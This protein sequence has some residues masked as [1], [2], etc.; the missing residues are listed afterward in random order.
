MKLSFRLIL[1]IFFALNE[2]LSAQPYYFKR[3]EVE[4][5]LSTNTIFASLQ[6]KHG[7]LW[8]GTVDGLNRF[9]GYTFKVFRPDKEDPGSI[10]TDMVSGLIEDNKGTLWVGTGKGLYR[11]N[12]I[13]EDFTLVKPTI[14]M[15]ITNLNT[16][17]YGNVW[18]MSDAKIFCYSPAR[19]ELHLY[20]A[21]NIMDASSLCV[22]PD[23]SIWVGTSGGLVRELN[24]KNKS[25]KSYDVFKHSKPAKA[26]YILRIYDA[27]KYLMLGT[28][29][30]GVK[31]FN[32]ESKTYEDILTHNKDKSE[33]YVRDFLHITGDEYWI[34]TEVGIFIYNLSTRKVVNLVK[35]NVNPYSLSDNAVYTLCKDREGGIW[36][37]SFFGGVNYYP[38]QYNLFEKFFPTNSDSSISGNAVRE[39]CK[40]DYGNIWVGTEDAALNKFN[41]K[42]SVFTHFSPTGSKTDISYTNIH[43]LLAKGN[44]LW[45]GTFEHGL[46]IM[47]IRTN[48][49]IRHYDSGDAPDEL[50]SN[51]IVTFL[52]TR[53]GKT[54]IGTTRGLYLYNEEKNNFT[55]VNLFNNDY[56]TF[57]YSILEDHSGNIWIGTIRDGLIRLDNNTGKKSY[58]KNDPRKSKSLNSNRINKILESSGGTIWLATDGGGLC[59]YV[60]GSN[61]FKSYTIN[62]GLPSNF[63]FGILE[64]SR[65]NLWISTSKGLVCFNP[66]SEKITTFTKS[67]GLLNDKFNYNSAFKDTTDGYMYFG[68]VKGMIRFNPDKFTENTYI[69]PVYI[70]GFEV[71]NKELPVDKEN[72]P[73]KKSIILT[74][75][76]VLTYDQSSFNIKFAALSFTAPEMAEYAYK[77]EGLDSRW[78]Y[79]KTNRQAYFT[80]LGPGTYT[81]HVKASNSSGQWNK[82]DTKLVVVILP[83]IW[84]SPAAYLIYM[85]ILLAAFYYIIKRYDRK[86]KEKNRRKIELLAHK[87]EQEVYQAKINF[88]T[89]VAH[90][91]RTPLTLIKGPMER[92]INKADEVP[93]IK[94]NLLIMERNTGRLLELTEQLLD[95]RQ[96]ETN[97][98]SLNFSNVDIVSLLHD[99]HQR[100]ESAAEQKKITFQLDVPAEPVNVSTDV[101]AFNK[102]ISN[103]ISNAIKYSEK[104][105]IVSLSQIDEEKNEFTIQVKNDGYHIPADMKDKIFDS[106]FRIKETRKQTGTGIGL[107]LSR[108]LAELLQGSLTLDTNDSTL[109]VFILNLPT[110]LKR[111]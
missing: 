109:N 50:K 46:D 49:V 30:Q 64:D 27:G 34:A 79:L 24:I 53:T 82:T 105:V 54:Y 38:R 71:Y 60:P 104:L 22:S 63:I 40:D 19:H 108:S 76:I 14:G 97:S 84:K 95:F 31:L 47:D 111:D 61:T 102:I 58:F 100:F 59:K 20:D 15:V 91:I 72:S 36:V 94:K 70:T 6:D 101:D 56:R 11:Y 5:G 16:D 4:D 42:T 10:G 28:S 92:I 35:D 7:F 33:I 85:L 2:S 86:V 93:Y 18:F 73:L 3:Y 45:I 52:A 96:V 1:L 62:E 80:G 48:K 99:L 55:H 37:G 89:N 12:T 32:K 8:F 81:F 107:A 98:F 68:S 110:G 25:F 51:F 75:T 83:P 67:N 39:I 74:D 88:F 65:K 41:P 90:E 44:E 17:K 106:F 57:V 103:L 77:L 69:P 78:I 21:R 43:G 66:F 29:N 87:K 26:R 23:G 13:S 9:D